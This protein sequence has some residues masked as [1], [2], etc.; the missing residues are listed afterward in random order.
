MM[1]S[2]IA[3]SAFL[4]VFRY[5]HLAK[6]EE[7]ASQVKRKATWLSKN[8]NLADK[9]LGTD[10]AEVEVIPLVILNQRIG[11]GL[12]IDDVVITDVFL[13]ELFAGDGSYSSG[14][15]M[16]KEKKAVTFETFY[17]KQEECPSSG[18]LGPMA[19]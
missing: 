7:A 14:A 16:T 18:F 9:A 5:R 17:A 11:S 1:Y 12:V 3:I 13:L 2:K 8:L 6:L 15:A 10:G 19:A 4:R